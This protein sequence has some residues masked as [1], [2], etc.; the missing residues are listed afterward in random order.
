MVTKRDDPNYSQVSGYIPKELAL[1][2]RIACTAKEISQS[3][4]LEKAIGQWLEDED[5]LPAKMGKGEK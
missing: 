1:R 4:A 3:E 5:P 2:F